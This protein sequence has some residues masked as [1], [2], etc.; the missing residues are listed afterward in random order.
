[1]LTVG[2]F[3]LPVC[4]WP[5]KP[6]EHCSDRD[7]LETS[8]VHYRSFAY[9][10]DT[11]HRGH[12]H[13]YRLQ[14]CWRKILF[15]ASTG[16][17]RHLSAGDARRETKAKQER[18]QQIIVQDQSH[19]SPMPCTQSGPR[20]HPYHRKAIPHQ[21]TYPFLR[22]P[23]EIRNKIYKQVLGV[24]LYCIQWICGN[25]R[26]RSLSYSLLEDSEGSG[27]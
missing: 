6:A 25:R 18:S 10:G 14:K 9:G 7:V 22:L 2:L 19:I 23:G 16:P 27:P 13:C 11:A 5:W 21:G 4:R 15:N 12:Y 8:R 20:L 17:W 3:P 24:E 1:M 26:S